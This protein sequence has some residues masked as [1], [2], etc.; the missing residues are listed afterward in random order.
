[1]KVYTSN[2]TIKG[3]NRGNIITSLFKETSISRTIAEK[4]T[5][6]V[7]NQIKDSK[8]NFLTPSLIRELVNAKL[9]A[10]GLEEIYNNYTRV[11]EP[12]YEVRKKLDENPYSGEIVREYNILLELPRSSREIHFDGTIHIEDIEGFSHRP[13]AYSLIAEKSSSLEKTICGTI[14]KVIQNKKYFCLQP[15]IYGLTFACSPFIKNGKQAQ[16]AA[17]MI[18]NS[19]EIPEEK[20]LLSLELFT[21]TILEPLGAHRE[22]ASK[23]TTNLLDQN[24]VVSVDS[25]YCLKLIKLDKKQFTILNNSTEEYYPLTKKLFSP[26]KGIDLFVNINLEKIAEGND[27]KQ[28][29]EKLS[30]ISEEIKKL[31]TKKKEL[32]SKKHYLK[33]FELE[34]M[35]TGIGLTNFYKLSENF[36]GSKPIDFSN[37]TFREI[38]KL[39]EDNLLFGL[40][41]IKAQQR[42]SEITGKE[43]YSQNTLPFEECLTSK[44]CCFTGKAA[45]IK[46]L[47][48]L[49]DKK[50]KQIEYVGL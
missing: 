20:P 46:E 32:L 4:I 15:S 36:E 31:K 24:V 33:K 50:V 30:E 29:F 43:I 16:Q 48:E 2:E 19:C 21:P 45:T 28:F 37:K 40:A 38:S 14:K 22:N 35:K 3:F 49:I 7:E 6:E 39:F 41:S 13:Y 18:I 27:E 12:V 17:E 47:N 23:I 11:G 25:K 5:S 8:I 1:M 10:Y 9:L 42:F 34:E 44:K 26:T